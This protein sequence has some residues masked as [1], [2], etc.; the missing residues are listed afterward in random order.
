MEKIIPILYGKEGYYEYDFKVIPADILGSV[1]ENYLGYRLSKSKKGTII[2]KDA[3]KRKEQGIYYTPTFIVDYIVRNALKPVLERCKSVYDLNKIKVLDPAC[4][5]GSFL[6]KAFEVI[7][8]KYKEWHYNDARTKSQILTQNLYGVD[9]DGQAV[10]IARLN[11]LIAAL[12][13]KDKLPLLTDNIKN[14]NSLISGTDE[15]LKKYFG[16]NFRDKKTIQLARGIP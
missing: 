5:S 1:Y 16:K 6:I 13:S 15:E 14:G 10:E 4:G 2:S 3:K 8:E 12:D 9:L 11:L 7:S